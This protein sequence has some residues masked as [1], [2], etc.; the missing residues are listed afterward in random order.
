MITVDALP[1]SLV[2]CDH[3]L[4]CCGLIVSLQALMQLK[5]ERR[6]LMT[7]TPIQ[8]N[9]DE[10]W[11]LLNFLEPSVFHSVKDF[12][13]K[14]V[15]IT[16]YVARL[17]PRLLTALVSATIPD[18]FGQLKASHQVAELQERIRPYILRRMKEE[19]E[20]SI[21]PKEETV[22]NIELTNV[23]KQYYRAIYEKN[24]KFLMK[25]RRQKSR[26]W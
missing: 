11:V 10:L 5:C 9:L 7:G 20:K 14:Y 3:I 19:V 26:D 21:P 8:N 4:L 25:A 18:R 12:Q 15:L 16:V 17:L 22:I 2:A 23:Q 6:L 1:L 13:A 24:T